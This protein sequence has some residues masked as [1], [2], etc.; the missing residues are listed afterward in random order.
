[1]VVS[2]DYFRTAMKNIVV[3]TRNIGEA[4]T[5]LIADSIDET[6]AMRVRQLERVAIRHCFKE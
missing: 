6:A 2:G 5:C 1:M 3:L 4:V